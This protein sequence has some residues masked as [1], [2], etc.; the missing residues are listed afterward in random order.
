MRRRGLVRGISEELP[1]VTVLD[2][3]NAI[4]FGPSIVFNGP[5]L[6]T[7]APFSTGTG[8][9]GRIRTFAGFSGS[10]TSE[11]FSTTNQ[12]DIGDI[13]NINGDLY[14]VTNWSSGKKVFRNSGFSNT[15]LSS[16]N[17]P[18]AIS[19]GMCHINGDLWI[20]DLGSGSLNLY[21]MLGISATVNTTYPF[22]TAPWGVAYTGKHIA[23]VV[24]GQIQL[25][26][27]DNFGAGAVRAFTSPFANPKSLT[28]YDGHLYIS[29]NGRSTITKQ[30]NS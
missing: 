14:M 16:F 6:V 28:Y 18:S 19:N 4:E 29:Y 1:D 2:Q 24:G 13:E 11:F 30:G 8:I 22:G 21:K 10:Q 17:S 27:P 7:C 3:R 5:N 12:K 9:Q 26:D 15:E 23:V 25:F 20:S